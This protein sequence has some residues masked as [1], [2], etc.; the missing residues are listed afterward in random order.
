MRSLP[1]RVPLSCL[2]ILV[3]LT[4]PLSYSRAEDDLQF[5]A[6]EA[7]VVTASR[8]SEN[9]R[10]APVTVEV[11][12]A[13]EIKNSGAVN[14]WDFMRF[15]V[16]MLVMESRSGEGNR[17]IVSVRGLPAPFVDNLLVLLDGRSVYTGLSGGA[18]WEQIPV[19]IQDIEQIEI[20]RGPNA[21]L[22]G[23]NAGLG[24]INII[25]RHPQET[26][27]LSAD[28]IIGNYGLH[29]EQ[30]AYEQSK[31]NGGYRI[32]FANKAQNEFPTTSNTK[33]NDFLSS[34]KGNFRGTWTLTRQSKLDLFAGVMW[35]TQGVVDSL[36]PQ[37]KTRHH[38]QMA[39]YSHEIGSASS[40]HA[41]VSRR[42]DTRQ[43]KPSF[44][45]TL[46]VREYQY[47]A[48]LFQSVDWLDK[49]MQTIYG[50]SLRYTGIYSEEIFSGDARHK[51]VIQRGFGSQS[52]RVLP[53]LNLIGAASIER[54]DTGGTEPAYQIAAVNDPWVN[55][56]FRASYGVAPTI[57]TL[58]RRFA[59]QQADS[60]TLLVGS[61]D[62]KP[63][64]LESYELSY[65]GYFVQKKMIVESNLFYMN[66]ENL[67][68][69]IVESFVFFP[70]PLLTLSFN[71]DNRAIARGVEQ[72]WT[73]RWSPRH[74]VYSN[75]TFTTVSDDKASTNIRTGTP[76]HRVNLGSSMDLR[77]GFSG[78]L[79]AGYKD[80]HTLASQSGAV[81]D[82]RPYWR[83]DARLAYA[84]RPFIEIFVAGQNL[85][86]PRHIEFPDGLEI[87]RTYLGGV[88]VKF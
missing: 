78:T 24:V 64:R 32:S 21:A 69:T 58:Y 54:S 11:I 46:T 20:I 68:Q 4:M 39:K 13:E 62:V 9:V 53:R 85:A 75:Y 72:K 42:D 34:R 16:G 56:T 45:G 38:F 81:L 66:I 29:R 10:Q 87:P 83:F 48:E 8:R 61:P 22:Y 57:P 60:L 1:L 2:L 73:Y 3:I 7:K 52:W 33:A 77:H 17:A 40:I 12:T 84:P 5:F 6:E 82:I 59:N 74:S 36:S 28:G 51:N 31:E 19:Q 50:A 37:G 80:G 70:Q 23:S 76:R 26:Q 27:L 25:T 55:H 88:S 49:R 67:S 35:E 18:V 47:D 43:F 63:Q 44:Q 30:V 15:R 79:N 41:M 65:Q 14:L 71:N 86:T